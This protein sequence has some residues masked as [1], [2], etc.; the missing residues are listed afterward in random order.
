M[1]W[2]TKKKK[3]PNDWKIDITLTCNCGKEIRSFASVFFFFS[4][5]ETHLVRC[6]VINDPR[7]EPIRSP[8]RIAIVTGGSVD[9]AS[10]EYLPD[11]SIVPT[12]R[13]RVESKDRISRRD[14]RKSRS[15]TV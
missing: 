15:E 1:T 2:K 6:T 4:F 12:W 5:S 11:G 9:E 8:V 14:V 10:E 7:A 13:L 3:T